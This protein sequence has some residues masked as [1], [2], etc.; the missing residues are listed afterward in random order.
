MKRKLEEKKEEK[1]H[2]LTIKFTGFWDV[3][4]LSGVNLPNFENNTLPSF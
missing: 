1:F 3:T 2:V 4:V